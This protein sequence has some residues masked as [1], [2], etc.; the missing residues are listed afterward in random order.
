MPPTGLPLGLCSAL[1][2]ALP[3][4]GELPWLPEVQAPPPSVPADAPVLPSLLIDSQGAP[5]ASAKAWRAHRARLRGEWLEL[6][7]GDEA[8]TALSVRRCDLAPE[9]V[10]SEAVGNVTRTL[11][12]LQFEPGL[13]TEAYVLHP[14][15]HRG[16]LPGVV[17]FHS[18]VDH[19]IRQPAG[20]EGPP[21]MF[22]GLR[23]AE[24][25]FVAVCPRCY[26]WGYAG[27]GTYDEAVAEL[28][29]RHPTWCGMGKMVWDGV[30]ALDY[31]GSLSFVDRKRLG[32]I[33]HS[34]GAKETLYM[35]ALDERVRAAVSSEGGIGL[36]FSN[37]DAPWYLGLDV[38]EPG[39]A[40]DNHEVVAL[41]APRAFLLIGGED[42]D[43]GR[44]WPYIAAAK[45]VY[46]LLGAGDH[47]GLLTHSSG[48]SFP[49][50]AQECAYQWLG[51]YLRG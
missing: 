44:S 8:S 42:A 51:H 47:V 32:C 16:K 14:T 50:V 27:T 26:I 37:W 1:M 34:L 25:G 2:A 40:H 18:T 28:E 5:I 23:L 3:A 43:G 45:P 38:K 13:T 17:A 36:A 48:H 33:G 4:A 11:V 10:S 12:R 24:R 29:R 19:T 6:L 20:L 30:R 21:S 41:A 46:D 22:M 7:Y 39:F 31:L 15:E 9:V 49:P 35:A